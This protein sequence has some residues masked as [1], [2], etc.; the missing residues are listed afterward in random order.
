MSKCRQLTSTNSNNLLFSQ[1]RATKQMFSLLRLAAPH[2]AT[3]VKQP[4]PKK[5]Q[6]PESLNLKGELHRSDTSKSVH[7]SWVGLL[8]MFIKLY[9]GFRGSRES[10][11]KAAKLPHVMSLEPESVEDYKFGKMKKKSAGV[12]LERSEGERGKK[13]VL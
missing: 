2:K 12:E 5:L 13:E 8:H 10:R 4:I 6:H 9:K 11:V 7:R 1:L 3:S